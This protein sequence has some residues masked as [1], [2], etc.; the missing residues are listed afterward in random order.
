M[1]LVI[2]HKKSHVTVEEFIKQID[3][4]DCMPVG[5]RLPVYSPNN[6][7]SI[8]IIT[9]MW[10]GIDIGTIT[11]TTLNRKQKRTAKAL[12]KKVFKKESIDGGHRKRAISDYMLDL[13]P[14]DGKVWSEL[15]DEQQQEFNDIILSFTEYTELDAATKGHIFRNLNRTTDVNFI[16]MV[17]SYGDLPIANYI[18]ETVRT[19]KQINSQHH[20]LFNFNT[21]NKKN[22]PNFSYVS[23]NND[24][25][26]QDHAIARLTYRY[27]TSPNSLLGGSADSDIAT[28]Y[29]DSSIGEKEI[30]KMVPKMKRHLDFLV[31]MGGFRRVH[32][33]NGLTLRDFKTL[34]YVWMYMQD[35]YKSF[36]IKDA[37]EFFKAYATANSALL[38]SDGKFGKILHDP[39]KYSVP[40]MYKNFINAPWSTTKVK[41]AISYLI[42]EMPDLETLIDV[43]DPKRD[44]N[45]LEKEAK[46]AGQKFRCAIDGK[47]L[48]WKDAHAAHIIAHSKGGQTQFSNLAMVRAVYNLEM[49]SMNLND[50]VQS[51]R[52]A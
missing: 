4:I 1:K 29:E 44:F 9:N 36:E 7:K 2:P 38:L 32:F 33:K 17:N 16:E 49:G 15:S 52:S 31:K 12:N 39:S 43:R 20:D 19:V 50:Y 35:T 30:N 51:R 10:E 21:A 42:G 48:K 41:T 34:S 40:E 25:L 24:R 23:F 11:L 5:Q 8:A 14:I 18:R 37:E 46:L 3:T 22:E 45:L 26:K 13:F 6:E 27:M 28:M 47:V